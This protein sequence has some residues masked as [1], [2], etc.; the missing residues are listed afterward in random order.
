MVCYLSVD[1]I[2]PRIAWC[3]NRKYKLNGKMFLCEYTEF[4]TL[5]GNGTPWRAT[6]SGVTRT[7]TQPIT[8]FKMI[9]FMV[10]N[11]STSDDI[12][13]RQV[14]W[15]PSAWL[16]TIIDEPNASNRRIMF[17]YTRSETGRRV[18]VILNG[19]SYTDLTFAKADVGSD[20]YDLIVWGLK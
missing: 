13:H 9:G 14:Q 12:S 4:D 5:Q 19:G 11:G 2:I 6:S 8:D 3:V 1:I 18:W 15:Y 7:L 16:K 10:I 20:T 17:N